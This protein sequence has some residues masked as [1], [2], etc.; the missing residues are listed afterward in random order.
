MRKLFVSVSFFIITTIA[1]AQTDTVSIR[2]DNWLPYNG[3][4]LS[5]MPGYMI[6]IANAV[7]SAEKINVNYQ[8]MPWSRA[9]KIAAKGEVDC[10]IGAYKE[11]AVGFIFPQE[12]WGMESTHAFVKKG[13]EWR[14]SNIESIKK[15]KL[16]TIQDYTYGAELDALFKANPAQVE[17]M[18]GDDALDKNIKK[19][20]GGRV[21][22]LLESKNVMDAKLKSLSIFN[23]IESA[24]E[25]TPIKP[26]Y[27]ACSP[28]NITRS[29]KLVAIVDKQT[30]IL[31]ANGE[32]EKIML[33]YG[34]HDWQ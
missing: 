2:A 15:R 8:I 25:V 29:N 17:V 6:E 20:L 10:V 4:P 13:E 21:N 34:L 3:E 18:S 22:T 33:K 26:L 7:F 1:Q 16:A 11:D 24:G 12:P 19:L 32:L 30:K 27:L 14:Y 23:T 28:A 5:A 31:R 9:V